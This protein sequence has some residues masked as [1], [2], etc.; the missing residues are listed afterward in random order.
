[1]KVSAPAKINPFLSVGERRPDGLHEICSVMQSV[2]L[3]DV[4]SLT[5]ASSV[6]LD[7]SP[8]D[9][10]PEDESNLVIRA[11]RA[12]WAGS[13][14]ASG[15]AIALTKEIPTAAGLG[16]G[17]SDAAAA[18]V[19]L[20][21]LWSLGLSRKALSKT[22][23]ALGADVPFCVV[24]GTAAA[25]GAGEALSPLVVRAPVWWVIALPSGSLST[26]AVYASFDS[27]AKPSLDDPFEVADALARGDLSR[28]ASSLRNDLEPAALSLMPALGSCYSVLMDAGALGAVMSGS[29]TAWCALARDEVHANEIASRVS[30]RFDRVFVVSSL[31]RGPRILER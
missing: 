7:V 25:R 3:Y 21:E 11:V 12:L 20:N 29:G 27:V 6:T 17:S 18:L 14:I 13:G 30:P 5:P 9:A 26:A 23:A 2:S 31:D 8:T 19:G 28:L 1:L 22:G 15:A 10:A 24:G 4:L 16:G